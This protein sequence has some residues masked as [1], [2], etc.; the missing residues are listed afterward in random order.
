MAEQEY[1]KQQKLLWHYVRLADWDKQAGSTRCSRFAAYLLKTFQVTHA[2]CLDKKQMRQA[3][4]TM[5]RYADKAA[6]DKKKRL[7]Q[8]VMAT[9]ARSGHD[10]EWLHD[11]MEAWGIGRS[12][13]ELSYHDT[14]KILK[15]V[16][17][18][19]NNTRMRESYKPSNKKENTDEKG[20]E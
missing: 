4:A 15:T 6:H 8:V 3:I 12:L 7:R 9:V 11:Q 1:E 18:M 17:G 16:Q 2:N 20:Q 10:V 14:V 13:R 5:K 19:F